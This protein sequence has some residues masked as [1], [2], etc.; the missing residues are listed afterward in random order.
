[1]VSKYNHEGYPDPT[2]YEALKTERFSFR[3]F[4]YICSPFAGDVDGNIWKARRYCRFAVKKGY[5]PLAPHLLFPQFLD[6]SDEKERALGIFFGCALMSKCA[7]IWV[8]GDVI[9]PGMNEEIQ[10][11]KRK[12]Y[13]LRYFD[14][15]FKEGE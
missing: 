9:S 10:R 1:M 5:I 6:D 15:S 11:A 4:V 2:P 8:C 3:P 14:S 13:R 7:E 12:G